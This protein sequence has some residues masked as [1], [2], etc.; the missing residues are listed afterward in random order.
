MSI[1]TMGI[2]QAKSGREE[3]FAAA[4]WDLATWT[5]REFLKVKET[6]GTLLRDRDQPGR[7]VSFGPWES[8]EQITAWRA[9]PGFQERVARMNGLLENFT[10]AVLDP[11]PPLAEPRKGG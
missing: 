9:H 1:Y 4:W 8:L 3:A 2:W 10:P 7:F 5:A 6:N 11:V